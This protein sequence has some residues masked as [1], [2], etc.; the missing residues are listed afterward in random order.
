M[1]LP[2]ISP[3]EVADQPKRTI[4][5]TRLASYSDDDYFGF[6]RTHRENLPDPVALV[7][8]MSR[9][10]M[11]ILAG[12]REL[13]Q[14]ARWVSDDVYRHLLLR[15]QASARARALKKLAPHRPVFTLGSTRLSFPTE[16]VAECVTI[17]HGRARTRAI[18][19]RL[20]GL[21]GRWRATAIHVL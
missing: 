2:L 13:E 3:A 14:I 15:V 21:D 9:S 20:E 12:A 8:N 11:E 4:V 16:S 6:Q 7:E 10:L 19:I 5:N 18:A 17:V 1:S